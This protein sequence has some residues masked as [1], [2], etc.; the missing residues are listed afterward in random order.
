MVGGDMHAADPRLAGPRGQFSVSEVV[1]R[2]RPWDEALQRRGN[3]DGT[4]VKQAFSGAF[5]K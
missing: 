4:R 3:T 5:S 1:A 2:A